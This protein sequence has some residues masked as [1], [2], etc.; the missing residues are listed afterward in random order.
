M[1]LTDLIRYFNVADH[2]EDSSLYQD[3]KRAAAWHLG[4]RLGSLFQPIVDLRD[5]RVVGHQAILHARR[6]DGTVV[7]PAEAYALCETPESVVY[8]DRLCRTLHALNFW[9]SS[10]IPAATCSFRCIR[11]ICWQFR[12]STGWFMKRF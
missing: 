2:T 9:P 7:S 5:Q 6:E 12:T 8:F 11:A 3:G 4:L 10:N 1:P